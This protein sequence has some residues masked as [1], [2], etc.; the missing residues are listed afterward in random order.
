MLGLND[1]LSYDILWQA[2]QKEKQSNEIQLLPKTFYDDMKAFINDSFQNDTNEET[3]IQRQNAVRILNSL[4]ERR[5]QKILIYAAYGKPLPSSTT[6]QEA[7]I[8]EKVLKIIKSDIS[9]GS[10]S[11]KKENTPLKS[12]LSIPE[13][14][15][16]SGNKIGP[17]EKE[18]II[19]IKSKED[20]NFLINNG[21]CINI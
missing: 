10:V 4:F 2:Y 12:K 17:L 6:Q 11:G 7:D 20:V 1:D 21:I 18:Q 16:P 14:I 5:K 9:E 3:K 15:L 13:I 8:Y 19:E